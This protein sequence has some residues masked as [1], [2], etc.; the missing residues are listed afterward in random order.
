[1]PRLSPLLVC[2]L[3]GCS[4]SPSSSSAGREPEAGPSIQPEAEANAVSDA[5]TCIARYSFDSSRSVIEEQRQKAGPARWDDFV[6]AYDAADLE[7]DAQHPVELVSEFRVGDAPLLWFLADYSKAVVDAAVLTKL[8]IV[9]GTGIGVGEREVIGA[10]TERGRAGI[11][12]REL[13]HFLLKAG[14]I[15][16][17]IHIGS[18]VCLIDERDD[19]DGYRGEFIGEHTYYTNEENVDRFGFVVEIDAAGTIA[20]TGAQ[21]RPLPV[22][23]PV[24]TP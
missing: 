1:M 22:A 17:W 13:A 12:G 11:G 15:Q 19:G 9:D 24:A 5:P 14:V 21:P 16:T 8:T 4:A 7:P 20:I 6:K 23:R 2:A 10:L 18:E 3:L